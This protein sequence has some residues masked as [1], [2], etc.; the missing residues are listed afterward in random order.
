MEKRSEDFLLEEYRTMAE[1]FWRNE[2]AGER[3]V[4]FLITL[5]TAVIGAIVALINQSDLTR[6]TVYFAALFALLSLLIFGV[7]TLWRLIRRNRVTD[8]YKRAMDLVRN[9]FRGQD[10]RLREYEPFPAKGRRVPGT[11]GL[12]DT[13]SVVNSLVVMAIA[14]LFGLLFRLIPAVI[15]VIGCAAFLASEFSHYWFVKRQ[16]ES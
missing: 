1:S 7:V 3:R 10:E 12:V 2:E 11:G 9:F 5:V 4:N 13:V 14:I 16:Y 6:E 8:E 15:G